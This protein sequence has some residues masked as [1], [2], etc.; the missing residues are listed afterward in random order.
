LTV[1]FSNAVLTK[2]LHIM[3]I[4]TFMWHLR[5]IRRNW[6]P[7]IKKQDLDKKCIRLRLR[8]KEYCPINALCFHLTGKRHENWNFAE[9]GK[10][11]RIS[12]TTCNLIASAADYP[13]LTRQHKRI[14]A[15]LLDALR[16]KEPA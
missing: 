13:D 16:L 7:V 14:R 3:T 10:S 4:Q 2:A 11:I 8:S 5:R 9:A 6:K 12:E 1:P 15:Q